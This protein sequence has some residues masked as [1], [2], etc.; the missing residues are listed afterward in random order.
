MVPGRTIAV[1]FVFVDSWQVIT[2]RDAF[3]AHGLG[4][5]LADVA[6]ARVIQLDHSAT[7]IQRTAAS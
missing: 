6:E 3:A 7:S 1:H 4:V 2:I 5:D